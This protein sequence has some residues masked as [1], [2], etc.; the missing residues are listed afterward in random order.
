VEK[1]ETLDY[2][3]VDGKK[4]RKKVEYYYCSTARDENNMCGPE[5]KRYQQK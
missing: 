4:S 3:L 2:F 5:G 1:E